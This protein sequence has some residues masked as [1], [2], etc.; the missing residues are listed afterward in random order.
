MDVELKTWSSKLVADVWSNG[1]VESGSDVIQ[2]SCTYEVGRTVAGPIS[3]D[4]T[5]ISGLPVDFSGAVPCYLVRAAPHTGSS[6]TRHSM[7]QIVPHTA[8][9]AC[10]FAIKCSTVYL[11]AQNLRASFS[12]IPYS[13]FAL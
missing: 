1:V 13:N 9:P 5:D 6:L 12:S 11:H 2:M 10:R 8:T 4:Q 3:G 7:G